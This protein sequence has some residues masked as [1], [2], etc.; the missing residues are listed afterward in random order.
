ML[1]LS[2]SFARAF[3]WHGGV[4]LVFCQNVSNRLLQELVQPLVLLN[5]KNLELLEQIFVDGGVQAVFSLRLWHCLNL[6][7]VPHQDAADFKMSKGVA[8]R[9]SGMCRNVTC[10]IIYQGLAKN[11]T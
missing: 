1:A 11:C 9:E 10:E 8:K 4:A 5:S 2:L 6:P 3:D 7:I